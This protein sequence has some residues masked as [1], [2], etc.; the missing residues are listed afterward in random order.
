MNAFLIIILVAVVGEFLLG[1][2][3]DLLN[4]KALRPVPPSELE[5]VYDSAE[6]R[7]SQEYTRTTTRFGFVTSTFKLA[8]LLVFWFAGGFNYLDE[9]VRGWDY[10]SIVDGLLYIGILM[11][12]YMVLSLPFSVY[13]TF[14]IEER[15]GFNK[16]SPGTF[17]ADQVKGLALAIVVGGA[18]LAAVL[19]FFEYAGSY[20]W[21]YAWG[22]VTL[23]ILGLQFIGPTWIMPLFN[24][25]TPL[26]A[27]EL[28]EAIFD[29]A[30][31]VE[32]TIDNILVMDGSKRSS[33]ANAFFTGFG[34]QK[35]IALF[36]TLIE[37]HTVPELLTV[38]AHEIGHYK[39]KHIIQNMV[40]GIV[41]MG[42]VFFLLSIFLES[43]GLYEAFFMNDESIYSG[44]LFFALL[45]T[46]T[47]VVL[48]MAL[49]AVS[50][51]HEY[52]AD[53]WAVETTDQAQDL[54]AGLKKLSADNLSN[55]S[56]HPFYVFMN[57]SHPPL[58]QRVKAV[59]RA[60]EGR[61][62]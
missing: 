14:V 50:R 58:L 25:F 34:R 19:A 44:L 26:D 51:K 4:L 12:A 40:I 28:R 56:P 16:T 13:S 1:F 41:H 38:L 9:T 49:Q 18:V 11:V 53:R 45:Y 31:G 43:S 36:D 33:K 46:P 23:F 21:L 35:R 2:V 61:K 29:Y 8:L 54:V 3:A 47:E 60:G 6:Y 5:G 42:I 10:P 52:E 39:M 48:S 55:L 22:A 17:V 7:K 27:G 57:H 32:F 62:A 24:K 59:E 15:Y 30:R 20:A 37:K